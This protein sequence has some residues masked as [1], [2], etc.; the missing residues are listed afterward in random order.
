MRVDIREVVVQIADAEPVHEGST[1][2]HP[3][4]LL[5]NYK[6]DTNCLNPMPKAVV[7][8]DDML[9]TGG[10]FNAVQQ[11]LELHYPKVPIEGIFIAR[12]ILPEPPPFE[13]PV[14]N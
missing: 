4:R 14:L 5:E 13:L 7:I 9:T 11:L 2:R 6:V 12:R 3:D 8:F 10:H 1:S